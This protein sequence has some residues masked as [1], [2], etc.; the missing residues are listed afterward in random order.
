VTHSIPRYLVD[1]HDACVQQLL[2]FA[3]VGP[4]ADGHRHGDYTQTALGAA[5][6]QPI[7]TADGGVSPPPM[8]GSSA[9]TT[10]YRT[11]PQTRRLIGGFAQP[12]SA[13]D[14]TLTEEDDFAARHADPNLAESPPGSKA[15]TSLAVSTMGRSASMVL[16][17]HE[18]STSLQ[19]LRRHGGE[20]S[21]A[22]SLD[23]EVAMEVA[24]LFKLS[25]DEVETAI[26]RAMMRREIDQRDNLHRIVHG[27]PPKKPLV[28]DRPPPETDDRKLV[29]TEHDCLVSYTILKHKKRAALATRHRDPATSASL[30]AGLASS[31]R[32]G[33]G[34]GGGANATNG[35][36]GGSGGGGSGHNSNANGRSVEAGSRAVALHA[37]SVTADI[38]GQGCLG[39]LRPCRVGLKASIPPPGAF[40][41]HSFNVTSFTVSGLDP[42]ARLRGTGGLR[43]VSPSP[44]HA[45]LA[46]P[47]AGSLFASQY[48]PSTGLRGGSLGP[49]AQAA[50][51]L[52]QSA[53]AGL[54]ASYNSVNSVNSTRSASGAVVVRQPPPLFEPASL[55][56]PSV[57]HLI[58]NGLSRR[59]GT[60]SLK[61]HAPQD[62]AAEAPT[63]AA[64]YLVT[65]APSAVTPAHREQEE[66]RAEV[67]QLLD[68]PQQLGPQADAAAEAWTQTYRLGVMADGDAARRTFEIVF[69]VLI[70]QGFVWKT[71]RPF[72]VVALS[73][74]TRTKLNV[75]LARC[76]ASVSC[77]WIVDVR[78]APCCPF[79]A[80]AHAAEFLSALSLRLSGPP[81]IVLAPPSLLQTA[82]PRP[83]DP[84]A[85]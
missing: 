39:G 20:Q 53:A 42:R 47:A 1:I 51:I 81:T 10:N 18:G 7:K 62:G 15:P 28:F 76:A 38:A 23:Q 78:V 55:R 75:Q 71:V 70:A 44:G 36:G 57:H 37:H 60:I 43:G 59:P 74:V 29:Q 6:L 69:E 84:L 67:H 66:Q 52:G 50:A 31:L 68:K 56:I 12:T 83:T 3:R 22:V 48:S 2:G 21:S 4:D 16:T 30:G 27:V 33:G 11:P 77:K 8:S 24:T 34:I 17:N 32:A 54:G 13:E 73:H 79:I 26:Q 61:G 63:A 14:L 19:Y 72:H 80:L 5:M 35:G 64:P 49:N 45:L 40:V 82:S 25:A 58:Y 65:P 9:G 85:A 46:P 41:T